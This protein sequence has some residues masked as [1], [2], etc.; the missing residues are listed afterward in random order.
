MILKSF[1]L[2][3]LVSLCMKIIN[4]VVV[5]GLYYGFF[6]TFSIG[7]SY[8]LLIRAIA[9]E[10]QKGR[11]GNVK[12]VAATTG[13]IMGQ[14][15]ILLSIYS[16]PL[17][18]LLGR[19]HIITALTLPYLFGQFLWSN[20][21]EFDPYK[22]LHSFNTQLVFLNNLTF[23][24]FYH[25]MLPNIMLARSANIYLF[26]CNNKI[27]FVISSFVSW[28]IG[29]SLFIKYVDMFFVWIQKR[30]FIRSI[31]RSIQYFWNFNGQ[32]RTLNV[33][34]SRVR[35]N[36]YLNRLIFRVRSNKELYILLLR[37]R[38]QKSMKSILY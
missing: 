19:P 37:F 6:T 17:Y 11:Q 35:S 33:L 13:F 9:T 27:L 12:R 8:F 1:L 7:S 5:V 15:I 14:L 36:K 20:H 23:P 26:Q 30:G 34:L 24:L 28:L 2:G 29:L 10:R 25:F 22:S 18:L 21:Y 31:I 32:L 4:S 16:K 3:N 38:S